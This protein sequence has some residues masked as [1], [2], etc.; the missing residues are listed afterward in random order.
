MPPKVSV[1]MP[2]Y[3]T[4][5]FIDQAVCSVIV[6]TYSDWE[7]LIIDDFSSDGTWEKVQKYASE[8]VRI[9]RNESN[10]GNSFTINRGISLATGLYIAKMDS[11]DLSFPE[12]I[13]KQLLFL[14]THPDVDVVGCQVIKTSSDLSRILAVSAYPTV[15]GEITKLVT[16]KKFQFIFGPNIHIADG[17]VLGRSDWFRKWNYDEKIIIAQDFD[18]YYRARRQ[19]VYANLPDRLYIW[20]RGGRTTPFSQQMQIVVQRFRTISR[21]GFTPGTIFE[22]MVSLPFLLSRPV[23]SILTVAFHQVAGNLPGKKNQDRFRDIHPR[24]SD[25]LDKIKMS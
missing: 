1:I 11:D 8:K 10:R 18:I 22:S 3:N 14:E 5:G 21:Y 7:L 6:Q 4:A 25:L 9:F 17:T 16:F 15:H 20:R 24:L 12:R 13:E 23:F 19:S 2:C